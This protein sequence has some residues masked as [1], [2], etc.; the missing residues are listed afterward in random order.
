MIPMKDV[1]VLAGEMTEQVKP[2]SPFDEEVCN[3]T[4]DF[5][6][7]VL[8]DAQARQ[9]PDV[10]SLGYWC[11]AA[12]IRKI[13]EKCSD[14]QERLGRGVAFHVAPANI[15]VNFAF[16]YFFSLL[17]GNANIVRVPTKKTMERKCIIRLIKQVMEGYK[18]I[19][20]RTLFVSYPAQSDATKIFSEFSDVRII[21]GG[22][23]TIKRIRLYPVKPRCIDITFADRYSL[24]L[25]NGQSVLEANEKELQRLAKA[26]YNDTFYMDQNACSSPQ[27]ILWQNACEKAKNRFWD[28]VYDYAEIHYVFPAIEAVNKYCRV[29]E[30]IIDSDNISSINVKGNLLVRESLKKLV[31]EEM[32]IF[33]GRCGQFFE[34]DLMDVSEISA[35]VNEKYQ[36]LSYYGYNPKDI[37]KWIMEEGL[38]GIDRIV[39][40]GKT[41]EI[42]MIWDGY[43]LAES[44]S[45]IISAE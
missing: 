29:C 38:T 10:V 15:P 26:F 23:E 20:K 33:R 24:A 40:V 45:R 21:W 28:A 4:G 34:Y 18:E 11:R 31:P 9:M 22:D 6:K 39:P 1:D 3:F 25:F 5:S 32:M 43:N 35:I 2:R 42:G 12:N 14:R 17:A 16:S 13:K 30:N 27:L 19:A 36:T 44:L 8:H 41:M 37:Q 7:A